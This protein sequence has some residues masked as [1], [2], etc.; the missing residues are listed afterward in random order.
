MSG[1]HVTIIGGG[2][3]GVA[4]ANRLLDSGH[5]VRVVDRGD[6][7]RSCS[8][9]NAGLM[10]PGAV[11]PYAI[12]GALR[13]VPI[14]LLDPMGPLAIRWRNLPS[15]FPWMLRW[16]RASATDRVE[17]TSSAMHVLHKDALVNYQTLL[18]GTEARQ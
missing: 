6:P 4:C 8:F 10:S 3:L 1:H 13:N 5:K 12:P 11:V 2:I 9:G 16:A 18:E 15:T 17:R 14:W 7:R